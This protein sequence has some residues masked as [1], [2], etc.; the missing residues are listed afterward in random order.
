MLKN[1]TILKLKGARPNVGL[2]AI[3]AFLI[4]FYFMQNVL[5]RIS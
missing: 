5:G 3:K 1:A 4:A 2:K